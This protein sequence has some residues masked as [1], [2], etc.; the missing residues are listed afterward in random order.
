MRSVSRACGLDAGDDRIPQTLGRGCKRTEFV[1]T[2]FGLRP[3]VAVRYGKRI[4]RAQLLCQFRQ[5]WIDQRHDRPEFLQVMRARRLLPG[6]GQEAL[7][8]LLNGLLQ[9]EADLLGRVRQR[10]QHKVRD[11]KVSIALLHPLGDQ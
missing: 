10:V 11:R 4:E 7:Q 8:V 5:L 3:G 6:A 9:V 2:H 1:L